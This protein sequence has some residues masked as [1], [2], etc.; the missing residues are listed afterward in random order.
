MH[1]DGHPISNARAS[2]V[3]KALTIH[4]MRFCGTNP[5]TNAPVTR[6]DSGG[7]ELV[8]FGAFVLRQELGLD[9]D[10]VA[11]RGPVAP[12]ESHCVA[13]PS[14]STYPQEIG[15]HAEPRSSGA[16]PRQATFGSTPR[17]LELAG[18]LR[19]DFFLSCMHERR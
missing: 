14:H 15:I 12:V 3:F 4:M 2:A 16:G 19:A 18:D 6:T 11:C 17:T 1:L 10:G 5:H 7:R 13:H 8:V 9:S